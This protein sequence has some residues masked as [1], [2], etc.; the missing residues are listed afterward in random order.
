MLDGLVRFFT[1]PVDPRSVGL[2]RIA[3]GLLLIWNHLM[4]WPDLGVLLG[5]D[6]AISHQTVLQWGGDGW[7][8]SY[9][10][11]AQT[12]GQT[13]VLHAL[14]VLPMVLFMVGLW[15]RPMGVLAL[16]VQVAI[17]H[18]QPWMQL[19]G[20]RLLRLW[21]LAM[22]L[23]PCGAALSVDA[24]FR[25]G[26]P[27]VVPA[28]AHRMVQ[29]QLMVMYGDTFLEKAQ[30]FSWWNGSALYYALAAPQFQRIPA[31]SA[32]ITGNAVGRAFCSLGTWAT[33]AWEATFLPLVLFRR[34]RPVAL[35]G[36]VL[37]HTGIFLT[38]M[39]GCFSPAALWGYLAFVDSIALGA[40]AE[41]RWGAFRTL[42]GRGPRM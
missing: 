31:L 28:F 21:T 35:W 10:A 39:V 3:L 34:T 1:A 22:V 30:G 11:W 40:W 20:D 12:L 15:S 2:M 23:V 41:R 36:G 8:G 25:R 9:Y 13:Q 6:A 14:G 5:P 33:L 27:P 4:L 29:I 19:G 24:R 17:H 42:P 37:V 7:G 16:L 32:L 38:M 18:Q 26:P